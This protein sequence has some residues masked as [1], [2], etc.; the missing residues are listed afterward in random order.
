MCEE[1]HPPNDHHFKNEQVMTFSNPSL[2]VA[3]LYYF[4][5][6]IKIRKRTECFFLI[7]PSK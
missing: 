6:N 2:L 4:V 1:Q 3:T 7:F 5:G